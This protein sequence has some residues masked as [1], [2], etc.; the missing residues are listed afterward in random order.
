MFSDITQ[1]SCRDP[2]SLSTSNA[3]AAFEPMSR[4]GSGNEDGVESDDTTYAVGPS[5]GSE[6][7]GSYVSDIPPRSGVG[8]GQFANRRDSSY[9][10]KSS[11]KA[12]YSRNQ[13]SS[14]IIPGSG[15]CDSLTSSTLPAA[16]DGGRLRRGAVENTGQRLSP[17]ESL[18]DLDTPDGQEG[19]PGADVQTSPR[20]EGVVW[21]AVRRVFG[22]FIG[23]GGGN[24]C[25]GDGSLSENASFT[26]SQ[27]PQDYAKLRPPTD[28]ELRARMT[29]L[30]LSESLMTRSTS[31][32]DTQTTA[33]RLGSPPSTLLVN[34]TMPLSLTPMQPPPDVLA[35]IKGRL[36]GGRH[37]LRS[38]TPPADVAAALERAKAR[39]GQGGIA[40]HRGGAGN[41]DRVSPDGMKIYVEDSSERDM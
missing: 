39:V 21:G 29:S 5:N 35:A 12:E 1:N 24:S 18:S 38:V 10:E 14:Q 30:Q 25:G 20:T 9:K 37:H 11:S 23:G 19:E 6:I 4:W 16:P 22:S 34:A 28:A 2:S 3:S 31:A 15:G 40:Y 13:S 7:Y 17:R 41:G 27:S 32:N 26:E 36:G 8:L 33:Q